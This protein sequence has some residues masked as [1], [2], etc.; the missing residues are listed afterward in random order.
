MNTANKPAT[1]ETV[2]L[3][4]PTGLGKRARLLAAARET[5]LSKL[6]AELLAA[7]IDEELPGLLL[8]FKSE[9]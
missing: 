8:N 3:S 4:L 5:S 1:T 2:T 9:G 7:K 6:V